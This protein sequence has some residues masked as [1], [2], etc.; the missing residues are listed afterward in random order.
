MVGR[1]S[2][3]LG[4]LA[5]ATGEKRGRRR[6]YT[7]RCPRS[8]RPQDAIASSSPACRAILVVTIALTPILSTGQ[9]EDDVPPGS[10][11]PPRVDGVSERVPAVP[12]EEF[13]FSTPEDASPLSDDVRVSA[14]NEALSE[15][16]ID[17]NPI[18]QH[19]LVICGHSSSLTYMATYFTL[20]GGATWTLVPVGDAQDH[21]GFTFRFDPALAFDADGNVYVAYGVNIPVNRTTVVVSKSTDGGR[22][23]VQTAFVWTAN[24]TVN[25]LGNDKWVL[26]TGRDPVV[27]DRQNVYI[28]WTWNIPTPNNLDQQV[29]VSKSIDGGATFSAPPTVI[30]DNS[31]T[32]RDRALTCDPSVGPNGELYVSWHDF[33]NFGARH[34]GPF[35]RRRRD[36]GNRR[37]GH[38]RRVGLENVDTAAAGSRNVVGSVHGC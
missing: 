38:D 32:G 8:E 10:T 25:V 28:A 3:T 2:S 23:Y 1:T 34:G 15:V 17:V 11:A 5:G 4:G 6:V 33:D 29:A 26:A 12:R 9:D 22:S 27:T 21:L 36:L 20:D 19:N 31:L 13:Q 18:N 37:R 14:G 30:N 24:M 7:A 35:L 16:L